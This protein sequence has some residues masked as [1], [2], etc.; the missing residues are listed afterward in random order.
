[1]NLRERS[2]GAEIMC[3]LGVQTVNSPEYITRTDA[4]GL[5]AAARYP[6]HFYTRGARHYGTRLEG[7]LTHSNTLRVQGPVA[8]SVVILL[9]TLVNAVIGGKF[10]RTVVG[11]DAGVNGAEPGSA[12]PRR[13]VES[14]GGRK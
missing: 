13:V 1:M 14:G 5:T 8:N 7:T 11:E 2:L 4:R 10:A 12:R 9:G 3:G 6:T